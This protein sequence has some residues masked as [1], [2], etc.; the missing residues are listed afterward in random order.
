MLPLAY[1][2]RRFG[3][4][5]VLHGLRACRLAGWFAVL[6]FVAGCLPVAWGQQ[7]A[8]LPAELD[9]PAQTES[10]QQ[11]SGTLD[12]QELVD[13]W[14]RPQGLSAS[15][16]ILLLLTVLSLAPALLLMTTSFIRLVV[17][18]GLVR[19]ALGT[20]QLPPAQVI[21]S[22]A[23]LITLAVMAP[24]WKQSYDEAIAP[25][26]RNE[27]DLETAWQRAQ[28]P[29]RRF[30]A[31]QIERAGNQDTVWLFLDYLELQQEEE[32]QPPS[33]KIT[34]VY[35]GARPERG[36]RNVPLRAL[37][38]AFMLSEL[39]VAFL[40]GFQ[41]YLPF[42]IIDLVV[43]VVMVS[44]GMLMLPPAPI[45]LP[46]KLL[47]FVLVDGWHLVVEMLLVSFGPVG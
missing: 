4:L 13:S 19:Q 25:Y 40:I 21:T 3:P 10:S 12:P 30:L 6:W 38:P 24:V 17:V 29:V 2:A 18:L 37:L 22:L 35:Y 47:L 32:G 36:E 34:Y 1:P 8:N 26:N 39:K 9:A 33:E 15:L 27:I 11:Q 14:T 16:K 7:G 20:Q 5:R 46:L 28:E 43:A 42:L 41:I 31:R 23:L 45:A 44:M